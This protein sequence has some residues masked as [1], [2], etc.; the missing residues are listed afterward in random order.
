MNDCSNLCNKTNYAGETSR[1]RNKQ[2]RSPCQAASTPGPPCE[3]PLKNSKLSFEINEYSLLTAR[4]YMAGHV[5]LLV[6]YN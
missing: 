2:S 3:S 5:Y 1:C 6:I 4:Q